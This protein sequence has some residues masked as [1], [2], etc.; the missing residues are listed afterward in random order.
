MTIE[1][2]LSEMRAAL[3]TLSAVHAQGQMTRADVLAAVNFVEARCDEIAALTAPV[4][5]LTLPIL[6]LH[7]VV[8]EGRATVAR[9]AAGRHHLQVVTNSGDAA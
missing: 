3:S 4:G 1:N 9:Q 7:D 6:R 8:A 2:N 5:T